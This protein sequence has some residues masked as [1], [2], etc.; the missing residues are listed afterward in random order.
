MNPHI[1]CSSPKEGFENYRNAVHAAGGQLSGGYCPAVDLSY[2]GLLLCGGGDISPAR[3]GQE[4]NGSHP[5]DLARDEAEF[6]LARAYLEAGK[7]ILGICRGHQLLN[8][9][10]G[11]TLLQDIGDELRPFHSHGED[12]PDLVHP[13]RSAPGS[14]FHQAYGSLFPINSWHHQS[15]D[16]MGAGLI[17]TLWS[18]SGI[19]EG[20]EHESLPILG[21]QFHPERITGKLAR[22]DTVDGAALFRHFLSFFR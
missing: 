6:A 17:P 18:E 3:Y 9:L 1:L 20:M 16:R 10:L 7:P 11:G 19:V 15:A 4:N 12:E 2:D 5:P 21:V 22:I 13:V 14:F 8:V